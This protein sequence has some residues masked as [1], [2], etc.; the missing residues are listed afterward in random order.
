M[1]RQMSLI[2]RRIV[3]HN[4]YRYSPVDELSS[5]WQNHSVKQDK[6]MSYA[7]STQAVLLLL[8]GMASSV[9]ARPAQAQSETVLYNFTGGSDGGSSNSR[10]TADGKGNFYGTTFYGGLPSGG[11]GYGTVFE[12][13]PKGN[14]GWAETVIYS[15]PVGGKDG[16]NPSGYLIFDSVGNL[17]GTTLYG[18]KGCASNGCGVVFELSPTGSSWKEKVLYKFVGGADDGA[19]PVEGLVMD[20][21]GNLYGTT[22]SGGSAGGGTVFELSPSGSRWKERVIYTS[23]TDVYGIG[24]AAGL[25]MDP[26]GN[27]LGANYDSVFELSPDGNGGWNPTILHTF[28]GPVSEDSAYFGQVGTP[29]LDQA[30]DIYG[31]TIV[32]G[33]WGGVYKLSPAKNGR[34]KEKTIH[35]FSGYL[36]DHD[37]TSP[38]GALVINAAGNIYGATGNGGIYNS[39]G[40]VFELAAPVGSG[41]YEHKILW[42]FGATGDGANPNGGLIQ[43]SAGNLYGTTASGGSGR[44]FATGVVFEV[45]P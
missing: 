25:T 19:Y 38:G 16:G 9:A 24:I 14:G 15:F 26:S 10:L 35:S 32:G 36:A 42:N 3:L 13:S 40:T 1:A 6:I 20:L 12:L 39:Q 29:V 22:S 41:K 30:G 8:A 2:K 28:T 17:Y 45:T 31:T 5:G 37:G 27:I 21:A 44:A 34:W 18:G 23:G 43:D 11:L 4:K 7:K 33:S